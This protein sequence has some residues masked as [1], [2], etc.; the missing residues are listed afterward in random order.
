MILNLKKLACK[1]F[2]ITESQYDSSSRKIEIVYARIA[3]AQVLFQKGYSIYEIAS[4]VN[5]D[6]TAIFHYLRTFNDRLKYDF[7]FSNAYNEFIKEVS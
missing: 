1:H 4:I 7:V 2:G 6:R 5:K 3:I